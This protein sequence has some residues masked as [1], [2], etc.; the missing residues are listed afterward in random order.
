MIVKFNLALLALLMFTN[1]FLVSNAQS[2][3][4]DNWKLVKNQ[5]NITV[6]LRKHNS[7][8]LKEAL[9]VMKI[10][11]SLSA[12]ISLLKD[13]PNYNLWMYANKKSAVLKEFNDFE[14]ILYTESEAP[15]PIQNR[16]LVSHSKIHQNPQNG[17]I[18]IKSYAVPA[19]IPKKNGLV[20]IEKM[21]S[22]WLLTP[23][24]G[25]YVEIKFK[26]LV[27]FGGTLPVWIMNLLVD[28]GPY[29]TLNEMKNQLLK[30]KYRDAKI[31]YILEN[32]E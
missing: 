32:E 2:N 21:N 27:N 18:K 5:N 4:A 25:G 7:S 8:S 3:T 28:K 31:T 10:K 1:L 17:I 29:N 13:T 24:N 22:E 6:Y 16:D 19:Y 14:R 11:T 15:W 23:L 20:R 30:K 26:I 9:G 12:V